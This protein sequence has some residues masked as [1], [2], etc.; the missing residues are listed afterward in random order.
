MNIYLI[1]FIHFV[2]S[3]LFVE[4]SIDC[5]S[6]AKKISNLK[7]NQGSRYKRSTER[8][9]SNDDIGETKKE[10]GLGRTIQLG[11]LYYANEDRISLDESLWSDK[12]LKKKAT[13]VLKPSSKTQLSI[14]QSKTDKARIFGMGLRLKVSVLF[15]ITVID[16]SAK[17]LQ[18]SRSKLNSVSI[19]FSY[20][21]INRVESISQDLR[22]RLDHPEICLDLIGKENGPTHVISSIT[23]L[24]I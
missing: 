3:F 20:E 5:P 10:P 2:L 14:T 23:R 19:T 15:G 21:A 18:E 13:I 8:K 4:S 16:E 6:N 24:V 9:N 12:T 7:K 11:S 1:L 22:S 17:M